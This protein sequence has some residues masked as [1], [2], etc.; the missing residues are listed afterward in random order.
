MTTDQLSSS[1][2]HYSFYLLPFHCSISSCSWKTHKVILWYLIIPH[3]PNQT[4]NAV[5]STSSSLT[6]ALSYISCYLLISPTV[7]CPSRELVLLNCL[8][9]YSPM[10]IL[11]FKSK[12]GHA[13]SLKAFNVYL[14][15][16]RIR[17][18]TGLH[19][20]PLLDKPCLASLSTSFHTFQANWVSF[21]SSV[22][23]SSLTLQFCLCCADLLPGTSGLPLILQITV[24]H[25]FLHF[26]T[27]TWT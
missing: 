9:I 25:H 14:L 24:K 21:S 16:L 1:Y 20:S 15:G 22:V 6:R 27:A 5:G 23:P 10:Q 18:L 13:T 12:L 11:F 3:L 17:L 8:H 4:L 19:S 7:I 2:G 26:S